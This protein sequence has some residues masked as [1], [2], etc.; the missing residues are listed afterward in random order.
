[1]MPEKLMRWNGSEWVEVSLVRKEVAPTKYISAFDLY[2]YQMNQNTKL[3]LSDI[4]TSQIQLENRV[5]TYS[6][7]IQ[8]LVIVYKNLVKYTI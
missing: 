1:M 7:D 8:D 3:E 4:I 2:L 5:E 6:M